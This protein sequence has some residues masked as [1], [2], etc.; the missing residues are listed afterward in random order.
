MDVKPTIPDAFQRMRQEL[1]E[2]L[3]RI[4][5]GERN[6]E[7][8]RGVVATS[9][10]E[11]DKRSAEEMQLVDMALE[12]IYSAIE[13]LEIISLQVR[14]FYLLVNF[15]LLLIQVSPGELCDQNL[16]AIG[17]HPPFRSVCVHG[18]VPQSV[19]LHGYD[20]VV[21]NQEADRVEE[22]QGCT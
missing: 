9:Q 12:T 20:P 10:A 15:Y 21:P 17:R 11:R 18:L 1:D 4:T 22:I 3:A 5:M 8:L 14:K 7:Q 6:H 13:D 19:L 2:V 16:K